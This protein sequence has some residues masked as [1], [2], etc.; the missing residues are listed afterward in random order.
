MQKAGQDHPASFGLA[1]ALILAERN[2]DDLDASR[3]IERR[4]GIYRI[5]DAV[6]PPLFRNDT[7]VPDTFARLVVNRAVPVVFITR[8]C[9]PVIVC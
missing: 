3:T 1:R 2:M 5:G 8:K 4:S 9:S 7:D 6:P